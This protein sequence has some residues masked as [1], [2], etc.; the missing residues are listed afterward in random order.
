MDKTPIQ[1]ESISR[2]RT[3]LHSV[4]EVALYVLAA[5]VIIT[6]TV[7]MVLVGAQ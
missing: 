7:I 5:L 3:V 6:P 2:W 1:Y 4:A